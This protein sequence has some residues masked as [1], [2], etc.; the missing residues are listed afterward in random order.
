VAKHICRKEVR[1]EIELLPSDQ[2]SAHA[3]QLSV[4]ALLNQFGL[5]E[6]VRQE[7]A[8]DPRLQKT[9]G[10]DPEVV[11]VQ[12]V[13]CFTS[14]GVSLAD[15]ERLNEDTALKALLGIA[16]FA[17]QTTLGEWL[18][19]VGEAGWQA[20]RR[21]NR[22]F[23]AWV[24]AQAEPGRSLH[25][26]RLEGF[27]D[28]TQIEVSGKNFEGA[29]L[30]Y[31]GHVALSWQTLWAGPLLADGILGATSETKESPRSE[32]AGRDVSNCLPELWAANAELWAG[33]RGYLYADS[34]SS[35]GKYL[36][37]IGGQF[38]AWSVSYN[39]WTGPLEKK[40]AELPA[41]AWSAAE[42]T[43]WNDGTE[44]LAQYASFTY[45]PG[46]CERP[47]RFAV[48]RHKRADGEFF[49]R[50]AFVAAPTGATD[51]RLVFEHHRLKG[52]RERAFSEVLSDLD[53]HHPPCAEL[54]ANR[55]FYALAGFAYNV[56]QALKLIHLPAS[57]APKRVGTLIRHLLLLPVEIK[58]HARRL[59]A[60]LYVP[61]GWLVWWRG[62]LAHL[63]PQCRQLG[64]VAASAG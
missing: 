46:G 60:C 48:V 15:A 34:A 1:F 19:E 39:K 58:R 40:A 35:A 17:D 26:G 8:L 7:V 2:A 22:A 52:D 27:F 59:K 23:V 6:R 41:W 53:L 16:A 63:L 20:V 43:K 24:L 50:Y 49:W 21:I 37:L 51:P 64:V 9:K 12:L 30:N 31:E 18:R 38:E 55:V 54:K 25:C 42:K 62:F 56:L 4:V 47:Q 33:R 13:C 14:G 61:A 28:D 5:W 29:K 32:E 3:G 10:F 36:E 44:H 57:E 11:V 45:Q